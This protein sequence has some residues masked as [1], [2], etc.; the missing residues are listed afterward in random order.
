MSNCSQAI[1]E[2]VGVRA[3][4]LGDV[5]AQ[6]AYTALMIANENGRS[7]CWKGRDSQR[8][9]DMALADEVAL[10]LLR[11]MPGIVAGSMGGDRDAA[12]DALAQA[13]GMQRHVLDGLLAGTTRLT[14][15]RMDR[16]AR[17]VERIERDAGHSA[18]LDDRMSRLG[19]QP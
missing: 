10:R 18:Y 4:K 17:A 6:H 1:A 8:A 9:P 5:M 12:V 11:E 14:P 3:R 16:L 19:V 13:A 2:G 7:A 15:A